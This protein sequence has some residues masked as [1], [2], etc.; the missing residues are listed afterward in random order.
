MIQLSG[1]KDKLVEDTGYIALLED[2]VVPEMMT[3]AKS[4]IEDT[5]TAVVK[6]VLLARVK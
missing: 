1:L 5:W 6:Q 2:T 4:T 3:K